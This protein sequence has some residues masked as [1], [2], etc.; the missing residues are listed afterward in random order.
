MAPPRVKSYVQEL[1]NDS[2]V[3]VEI[4]EGH[5][6]LR[7]EYPLLAA[8]DRAADGMTSPCYCALCYLYIVLVACGGPYTSMLVSKIR[9]PHTDIIVRTAILGLNSIA[10]YGVLI[11]HDVIRGKHILIIFLC[12]RQ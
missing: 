6:T 7:Q 4:I 8:V 1:F 3:S 5:E 10:G 9:T 2:S 12:S 11:S